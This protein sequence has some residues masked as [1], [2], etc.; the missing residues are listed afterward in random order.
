MAVVVAF[1][2]G[3]NVG[4]NKKVSMADLKAGLEAAGFAPV[5][6]H[7]NSGNVVFEAG[8]LTD[9][10]AA[11]AVAK[12][13]KDS[14]GV[15]CHVQVRSCAEL[16]QALAADPFPETDGSRMQINFLDGPTKMQA[17]DALAA[18][19]AGPERLKLDGEVIYGAFPDG[20]SASELFKVNWPKLLG[21][22]VTARN[23]NTVQKLVEI[24]E[25]MAGGG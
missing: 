2:R 20:V 4:G 25:A 15:D 1:L 23:R 19:I 16:K 8:R 24:A 9:S 18:K 14:A 7:L 22:E 21:V 17:F 10:Q 11:A 5:K 12:A 13:V 6:T 3:I